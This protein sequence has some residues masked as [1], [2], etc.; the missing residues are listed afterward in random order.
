VDAKAATCVHALEAR[1]QAHDDVLVKD[2]LKNHKDGRAHDD[3]KVRLKD[4]AVH[5]LAVM[6]YSNR[7]RMSHD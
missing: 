1:L 7:L 6:V 3:P 4:S 5:R 2:E